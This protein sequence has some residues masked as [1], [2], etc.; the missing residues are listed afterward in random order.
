M[1]NAFKGCTKLSSITLVGAT[2]KKC[3]NPACGVTICPAS[4][5]MGLTCHY[6]TKKWYVSE[7]ANPAFGHMHWIF[8][9]DIADPTN[10]A[11][12]LVTG[13]VRTMH[14]HALGA[15]GSYWSYSEQHDKYY[16]KGKL[17]KED[18]P[19]RGVDVDADIRGWQWL[20][21]RGFVMYNGTK[22]E[23]FD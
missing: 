16:F 8:S 1:G 5:D 13:E 12:L 18:D 2:S 7:S 11:K 20:D 4:K 10:A 6:H 17:E 19:Y 14:N 23:Y 3:E 21:S 9:H 22:G 15:Q